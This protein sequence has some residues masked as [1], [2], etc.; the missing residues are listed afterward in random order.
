MLSGVYFVSGTLYFYAAFKLNQ[1]ASKIR[2]FLSQ[3]SQANLAEALEAPRGFWKY[4]GIC[5][6]IVIVFYVLMAIFVA[7]KFTA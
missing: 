5:G 7:A 6:L 1:Y 3:A 4:V 2:V